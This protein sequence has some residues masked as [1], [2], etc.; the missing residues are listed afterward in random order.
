MG[1]RPPPSA[2]RSG[3]L[4]NMTRQRPDRAAGGG[5]PKL[6][7]TRNPSRTVPR[8][9]SNDDDDDNN[10]DGSSHN[11]NR[12]PPQKRGVGRSATGDISTMRRPRPRSKERLR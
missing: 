10:Y 5:A 1:R 8:S 6:P 9:K 11:R 12:L 4:S 3:D 2:T 7:P